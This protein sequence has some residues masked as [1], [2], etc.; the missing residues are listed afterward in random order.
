MFYVNENED[1]DDLDNFNLN[2]KEYSVIMHQVKMY[3]T[4]RVQIVFIAVILFNWDILC[5]DQP[6][7]HYFLVYNGLS[8]LSISQ[9]SW[10]QLFSKLKYIKNSMPSTLS[11]TNLYLKIN[12][13]RNY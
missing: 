8:T 5:I 6:V 2:K 4:R 13:S 9:V 10:E 7:L 12:Y 1:K 11:S 3:V